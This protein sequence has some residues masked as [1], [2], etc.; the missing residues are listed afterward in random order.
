MMLV[1][2]ADGMLPPQREIM[3]D[4]ATAKLEAWGARIE[5]AM[6]MTDAEAEAISQAIEAGT[7][8]T[9]PSFPQIKGLELD[10]QKDAELIDTISS[11]GEDG[12]HFIDGL[13]D[14]AAYS[15]AK[16]D[17]KTHHSY[18]NGLHRW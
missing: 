16:K 1:K 8:L 13:L 11:K 14:F 3:L 7:P 18:F 9:D 10:P 6:Q 15:K 17:G 12:P 4:G 5:E 2:G